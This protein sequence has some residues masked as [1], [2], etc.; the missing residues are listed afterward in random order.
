MHKLPLSFLDECF[1]FTRDNTR[2][3]A[4][5]QRL[6]SRAKSRRAKNVKKQLRR[7]LRALLAR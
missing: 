4:R 5:R 2:A 6:L 1:G 7:D 3:L